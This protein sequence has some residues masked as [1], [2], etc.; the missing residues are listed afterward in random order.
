MKSI[1]TIVIGSVFLCMIVLAGCSVDDDLDIELFLI[2]S[3][4]FLEGASIPAQY[5]CDGMNISPPLQFTIS[6]K[7]LLRIQSLA[8]IVDD[9]DAPN[10]TFV[11]WVLYDLPAT[12]SS[13]AEG[14]SPNGVL[15]GGSQGIN[16]FGNTGYG[17]PCPP[18]GSSHH[19]YFRLY[20][21]DTVLNLPAGATR[22]QVDQA[23][24]GH[25]IKQATLMGVYAR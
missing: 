17:G 22:A 9:P 21:L 6:E 5:T 25:I 10:G 8:L 7:T 19:Y 3:S 24:N 4:A 18:T 15:P 1:G 2:T 16:D 13:L 11:H 14:I 12:I 20:A 23:M